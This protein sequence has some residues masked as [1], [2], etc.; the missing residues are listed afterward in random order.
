MR[1]V[2]VTRY[3]CPHCMG[4]GLVTKAEPSGDN[5]RVTVSYCEC[6]RLEVVSPPP[7]PETPE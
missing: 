2:K 3:Q 6:Y 4:T 1:L 5:I 7:S